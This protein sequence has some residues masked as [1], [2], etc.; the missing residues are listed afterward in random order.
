VGSCE[1]GNE[2]SS[3]IKCR[4]F[5]QELRTRCVLRKD[6]APWSS[7]NVYMRPMIAK[8]PILW[9][10]HN[11]CALGGLGLGVGLL[12]VRCYRIVVRH[13]RAARG[14]PSADFH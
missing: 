5:L 3:F 9:K 7:N 4:Q 11:S 2:P 14:S 1:C 6:S 8:Q 10:R 12:V 13:I